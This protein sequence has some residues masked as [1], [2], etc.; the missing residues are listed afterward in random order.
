MASSWAYNDPFFLSTDP[1]M[2]AI[3]K[4]TELFTNKLCT[5]VEFMDVLDHYPAEVICELAALNG[6]SPLGPP[7]VMLQRINDKLFVI[8]LVPAEEDGENDEER[9]ERE[10]RVEREEYEDENEQKTEGV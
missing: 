5:Q 7:L 6:V 2:D 3:G 8:P 4:L 10:E 9:E 1:P